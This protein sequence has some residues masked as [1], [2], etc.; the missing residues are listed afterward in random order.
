MTRLPLLL[1]AAALLA[2]SDSTGPAN[3]S[4]QIRTV[5]GTVLAHAQ[6]PEGEWM[7][8][9]SPYGW[10]RHVRGDES[11]TIHGLRVLWHTSDGTAVD[12]TDVDDAMLREVLEASTIAPGDSV[13]FG[14]ELRARRVFRARL[15][16]LHGAGRAREARTELDVSCVPPKALPTGRWVL[17]SVAG[18]PLPFDQGG[19]IVQ[20]DTLVFFDNVTMSATAYVNGERRYFAPFPVRLDADG[21]PHFEHVGFGAAPGAAPRI[22]GD[23][24]FHP[25]SSEYPSRF[26]KVGEIPPGPLLQVASP[27]DLSTRSPRTTHR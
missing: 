4:L 9:C 14:I 7:V 19:Q 6:S 24:M 12:S 13:W 11:V 20:A 10:V 2:C 26:E 25:G 15:A 8:R 21:T 18:Q 16:L 22:V 27:L 23:T 3:S 5:G 17:R 1:A